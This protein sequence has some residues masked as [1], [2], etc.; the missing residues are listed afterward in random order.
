[1]NFTRSNYKDINGV[2]VENLPNSRYHLHIY[3]R[4]EEIN[5]GLRRISTRNNDANFLSLEINK[6]THL[7]ALPPFNN[8]TY[9]IYPLER[10]NDLFEKVVEFSTGIQQTIMDILLLIDTKNVKFSYIVC[11]RAKTYIA[12]NNGTDAMEFME[13]LRSQQYS[14]KLSTFYARL[15]YV[16]DNN[17]RQIVPP[18]DQPNNRRPPIANNRAFRQRQPQR[19]SS[20]ARNN[21]ARHN[22]TGQHN[23][24]QRNFVGRVMMP[25][26]F[27]NNN[28][29]NN[30]FEMRLVRRF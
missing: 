20:D 15:T 16:E 9:K 13:L 30:Q 7:V 17:N 21:D 28:R 3:A 27:N 24:H 10:D 8:S 6:S 5:E 29:N 19:H 1:M 11:N 18:P 12:F 25:A 26:N 2:F 14:P 23:Q 4:N 22:V